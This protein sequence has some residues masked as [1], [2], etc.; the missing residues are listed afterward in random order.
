MK[1]H[2]RFWGHLWSN[3]RITLEIFVEPKTVVDKSFR[4]Y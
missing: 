2:M 4:K 1:S 3:P